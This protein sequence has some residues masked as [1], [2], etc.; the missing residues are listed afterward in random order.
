M[1]RLIHAGVFIPILLMIALSRPSLAADIGA[2]VDRTKLNPGESVQLTLTSDSDS[3]D[4]DTSSIRDF[5]VSSRG[6]SSS[7]RIVNGR[8][9]REVTYTYLLFPKKKGRLIIPALT[10]VV[11]GKVQHTQP[12]VVTVSTAPVKNRSDDLFV[13]AEISD[14]TPFEG[15]QI[16]YTFKLFRAV[17]IAN[18]RFQKP[19]FSGFTAKEIGGQKSYQ[20]VVSGRRYDVSALTYVLIPLNAGEKTIPPAVLECDVIRPNKRRRNH[21]FDSFFNDPFFGRSDVEPRIIETDPLTV[22]VKPLPADRGTVKFS[23]LVGDFRIS[24]HL[25]SHSLVVGDSTTLSVIIEGEG[26]IMDAEE[27]TITVPDAFKIYKDKPEEDLQLTQ[28][29]YSGKKI[30]RIALVPIEAGTYRL[31][32]VQLRY[33]D[34]SKEEYQTRSTQ[35]V[36]LVVEPSKKKTPLTAFTPLTTDRKPFRKMVEFTGRDILPLNES[37]DALKNRHSLSLTSFVLFLLAPAMVYV[38]VRGILRITGKVDDPTSRMAQR[39]DKALKAGRQALTADAPKMGKDV[40]THLYHALV[41]AVLSKAGTLGES[42]T[43]AEVK[44]ILHAQGYD[45]DVCGDAASL[46]ERI[47]SATFGGAAAGATAEKDL[48]TETKALVRRLSRS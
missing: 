10:V 4:V 22:H 5:R 26:N 41:S 35:S 17:R 19:A 12:I 43:Y 30:F 15:Q 45:D 36:S 3:I 25:D 44:T 23:G 37:L 8:M 18:A 34:T 27:P 33:F 21:P 39:A 40:H 14:T 20:A 46:L 47:E 9:S 16:T 24:A 48:Y 32:P 31:P 28:A 13:E 29:G 2:F 11:D 1:K 6:T 7:V 38:G 42:L